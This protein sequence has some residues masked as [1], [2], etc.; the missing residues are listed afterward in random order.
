[1]HRR[2]RADQKAYYRRQASECA[3]A[4]SATSVAEVKQA[5]LDLEQGWLS[6]APDGEEYP[7][8]ASKPFRGA[9]ACHIADNERVALAKWLVGKSNCGCC[10][11]RV[12]VNFVP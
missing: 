4:A 1:M 10:G 7:C 6:L 2:N 11:K 5:Y 12:A 3:A 8:I 9:D